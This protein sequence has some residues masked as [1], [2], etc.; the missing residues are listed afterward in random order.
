MNAESRFERIIGYVLISGVGISLFLEVA[1]ML[2]YYHLHGHLSFSEEN[3]LFL[4]GRNFFYF[5][6]ELIRGEYTHQIP[7]FLMA[8]G[9]VILI[10]TPFVRVI[11]SV[12]FF[13][14]EKNVKYV[15]ITVFVLALLT[16]SL[17]TR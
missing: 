7:L 10:L 9:I 3:I 5:L 15:V 1:G 16:M 14:M 13:S 8:L 6:V 17:V 2:L 12:F 4:H 11:L